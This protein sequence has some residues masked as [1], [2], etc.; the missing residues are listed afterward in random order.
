LATI[1]KFSI[2]DVKQSYCLSVS[3]KGEGCLHRITKKIKQYMHH[4]VL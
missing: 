2:I 4:N 3:E 1:K